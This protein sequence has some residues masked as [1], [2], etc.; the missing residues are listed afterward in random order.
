MAKVI[1]ETCT[2]RGQKSPFFFKGQKV[3]DIGKIGRPDLSSSL[4]HWGG[5]GAGALGGGTPPPHTLYSIPDPDRKT[6]HSI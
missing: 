5:G 2:W 1:S 6:V 3:V 4:R